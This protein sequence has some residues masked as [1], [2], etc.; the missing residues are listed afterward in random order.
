MGIDE[1]LLDELM[2][3]YKSPEDLL[4]EKLCMIFSALVIIGLEITSVLYRIE[5]KTNGLR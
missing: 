4:G 3:G 2:K 5:S 1:K